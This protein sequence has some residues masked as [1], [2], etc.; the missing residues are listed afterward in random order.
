MSDMPPQPT[1]SPTN[2]PTPT[3]ARIPGPLD[4]LLPTRCAGC[5]RPGA[6]CCPRCL[7]RIPLRLDE[8]PVPLTAGDVLGVSAAT[9]YAGVARRLLLAYKETDRLD[10]APLLG[11]LLAPAVLGAALRRAPP[12]RTGGGA[13]VRLGSFRLE[14]VPVPSRRR[15]RRRRGA[16]LVLL[17]ARAAAARLRAH[18]WSVQVTPV[19]RHTGNGVDQVGLDRRQRARN[20]AASLQARPG[21]GTTGTPRS[22][23]LVLVV[24]DILTTGATVREAVRALAAAGHPVAGAAVVAATP[25]PGDDAPGWVT[26]LLRSDPEG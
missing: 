2:T 9:D 18:G 1:P 14:L 4:L 22:G 17:L 15:S 8:T 3:R 10:L 19:L 6:A 21:H 13:P 26:P 11:G 20:A 12:V 7:D 5:A 16:D 23:T 24:D 25:L